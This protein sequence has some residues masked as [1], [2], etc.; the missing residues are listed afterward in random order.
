MESR[1]E[2]INL[3]EIKNISKITAQGFINDNF[4]AQY[5]MQGK[6]GLNLQLQV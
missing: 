2:N 5:K 6:K 1:I 4:Y 3:R